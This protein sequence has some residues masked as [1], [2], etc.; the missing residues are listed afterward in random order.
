ML[1]SL[2]NSMMHVNVNKVTEAESKFYEVDV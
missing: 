2:P 1:L